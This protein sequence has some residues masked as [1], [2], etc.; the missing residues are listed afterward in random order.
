MKCSYKKKNKESCKNNSLKNDKNCYWHSSKVTEATKQENRSKGGKQKQ[1]K[2]NTEFVEFE[3]NNIAD[4]CKLNASMVN[5]VLQ[6]KID[7]RIATG[8]GYL[9]NLQMK[10]I[11]LVSIESKLFKMEDIII[12]LPKSFTED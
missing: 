3:L 5:S 1:I 9:L 2:C 6:N 11:E 12:E 4:V 7:L 8:I 10:A